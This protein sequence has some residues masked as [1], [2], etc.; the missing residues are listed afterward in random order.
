M[1]GLD[2]P[3]SIKAKITEMINA[4]DQAAMAGSYSPEQAK[5]SREW[6]TEARYNLEATIQ[7]A[8]KKAQKGK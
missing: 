7:T 6:L 8:L 5:E 1:A 4:A 3:T 2:I